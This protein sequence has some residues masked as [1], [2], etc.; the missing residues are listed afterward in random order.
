MAHYFSESRNTELSTIFFLETCINN[1]WK[2]ITVVKSFTNAYKSPLP[3]VAIYLSSTD[4]NRREI[5]GTA[6]LKDYS[7]NI[8]IFAT[9]GGQRID[10]ADYIVEK[11]KDCWTYYLH[12]QTPGNPEELTRIADG[13]IMVTNYMTDMKIDFGENVDVTDRFR[14]LI[15]IQVRKSVGV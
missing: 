7:I 6:L 2:G 15:Q 1:D 3:V 14:H 11:L 12:S 8:D 5:G 10:L 13:S 4:N 9:S